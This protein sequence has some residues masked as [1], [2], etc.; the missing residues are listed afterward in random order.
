MELIQ[1]VRNMMN[2]YLEFCSYMNRAMQWVII[3]EN[4]TNSNGKLL[5]ALAGGVALGAFLG[6]LF[7][8]NKG[9]D[10]RKK[11]ADEAKKAGEKMKDVIREK[12][13]GATS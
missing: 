10:T 3:M 1:L 9:S 13:N 4:T 5:L 8:P 2:Y 7:A 12:M 6:I 11:M